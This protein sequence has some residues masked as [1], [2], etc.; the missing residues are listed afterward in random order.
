MSAVSKSEAVYAQ[1]REGILM[2]TYAPRQRLVLARIAQE[3]GMSPVPVREAIRR[4]EAEGFVRYTRNVGAEVLG[5][6]SRTYVESMETV[7]YL[8]GAATALAAPHITARDL[9][10]ARRINDRMRRSIGRLDPLDF[11]ALNE[12][13]HRLLCQPCPNALLFGLLS[14]EWEALGRVRRSS[15]IFVPERSGTSVQEH[16]TILELIESKATA[17]DIERAART[18]KLHTL[19]ALVEHLHDESVAG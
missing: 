15:F 18:H 13:F 2:G 9:A 16:D 19:N 4:L 8:E 17:A 6:T 10:A 3:L 11:T 7:A 5:M 12:R 1:L 14:R